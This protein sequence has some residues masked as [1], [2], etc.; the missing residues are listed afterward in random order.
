MGI[1][2]KNYFNDMIKLINEIYMYDAQ[3]A[4]RCISQ[5][6]LESRCPFGDHQVFIRDPN[7]M[8]LNER[9]MFDAK[10]KKLNAVEREKMI[11]EYGV[12]VQKVACLLKINMEI[13]EYY[14]EL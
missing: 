8:T 5:N 10:L 3:R 11:M 12:L 9:K 2:L 4:D 1:A 7:V 6:G 14:L 13:E